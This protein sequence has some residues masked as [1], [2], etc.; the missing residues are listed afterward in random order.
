MLEL[1]S[2]ID[3]YL[4]ERTFIF[5]VFKFDSLI[6][7]FIFSDWVL[8]SYSSLKAGMDFLIGLIF[9]PFRMLLVLLKFAFFSVFYCFVKY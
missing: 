3:S 5:R 7:I 6:N 1:A 4:E 8:K 9:I 2:L